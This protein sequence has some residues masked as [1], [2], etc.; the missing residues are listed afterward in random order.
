M[1]QI[2]DFFI[3]SFK[4]RK[5]LCTL[6]LLPFDWGFFLVNRRNVYISSF[7]YRDTY[8]QK[9]HE[10]ENH[11]KVCHIFR[12]CDDRRAISQHKFSFWEKFKTFPFCLLL[13]TDMRNLRILDF[14]YPLLNGIC[15]SI[16]GFEGAAKNISAKTTRRICDK[17]RCGM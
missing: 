9:I 10:Q 1:E 15:R 13:F 12:R 7:V 2:L 11:G 6:I 3:K 4:S 5:D 16:L 8:T 17:W 14:H